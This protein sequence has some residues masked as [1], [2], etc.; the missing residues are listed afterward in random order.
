MGGEWTKYE[1]EQFGEFSED[2]YSLSMD[3]QVT[4]ISGMPGGEMK[5]KGQMSAKRIGDCAG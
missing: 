2:S 5:M 1:T 4:G 3:N